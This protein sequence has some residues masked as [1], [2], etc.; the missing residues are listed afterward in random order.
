M[1]FESSKPTGYAAGI[2]LAA[3]IST[4]ANAQSAEENKKDKT[5]T[6][7]IN[8]T[9]DFRIYHEASKLET[10]GD[11]DQN[12]TT[13]EFRA[14]IVDGKWQFRT[15]LRFNDIE[16]DFNDDGDDEVDDSGVGVVDMRFLTVPYLNMK[17]RKAVATGIEI[18]LPTGDEVTGSQ[19]LSLGPQIFGVFFA[20]FG[21]SNSLIAPALQYKFS[22]DEEDGADDV[23]QF[24]FD[25]FFLKTSADKQYWMLINPQYLF[26]EEQDVDFGFLDAEFGMMVG[27][28]GQSVYVRPSVG[29]GGDKVTESAIEIGYKIIW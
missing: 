26:D 3:L 22:I 8:F 18:F 23:E 9:H 6:N 12:V 14:P 13:V 24:L 20:P 11:G 15:R 19:T 27:S 25:V 2:I 21:I 29:L 7:P 4:G 5:G 16:A 17:E 1:K 28:S 10:D